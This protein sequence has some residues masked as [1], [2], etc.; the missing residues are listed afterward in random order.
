MKPLL[1]TVTLLGAVSLAG[2]GGI[3]DFENFSNSL[4]YTNSVHN[5]PPSGLI[6]GAPGAYY[7]ALF[8]ACTNHTSVDATLNNGIGCGWV[9]EALGTN[10]AIPGLMNGNYTTDPGVDVSDPDGS[11]ANFV[12]AG[13]SA[14]VGRTWAEAK[15]WWGNGSPNITLPGYFAISS[16]AR[17]VVAGGSVYPVP[18]IFGPTPI[19]EVQGFTLNLYSNPPP[20]ITGV[21]VSGT[22]VLITFPT[23]VD[24]PYHLQSRPNLNLGSWSTVANNI[25]GSGGTVTSVHAGGSQSPQHFYRVEL[26]MVRGV[27][28][29]ADPTYAGGWFDGS[30]GCTNGCNGGVGFGPWTLTA[31][32]AVGGAGNGFLIGSSTNNGSGAS[33]GIDVVG[34]SWGLYANS[35]NIAAAW[36]TF[37]LT[38]LQ[39]GQSFQMAMDNGNID[40]GGS[41]GLVLHSSILSGP[42]SSTFA[43]AQFEFLY[44]GSDPTDSYK[45][46][47][48][49]GQQNI[50]VPLTST[51]LRLVFTLHTANTY[52]LLTIDNASNTTNTHSG[53]L[54]IA[55]GAINSLTLF[56]NNAGSGPSHNVF[57]NCF[58]VS[59]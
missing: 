59:P 4:I 39:I 30:Y 31:T 32:V 55:N 47:D 8:S 14:N 7:F 44:V 24:Y 34:K 35:G 48:A 56:N 13:W 29:A 5:G 22:N 12:V 1:T 10:T 2:A 3:V 57:F 52:T 51:G 45:V 33:P 17:N 41:V 38:Q 49:G 42:P 20:R 18:T 16:I 53:T 46:V 26:P 27:D 25:V 54:A 23:V 15:A 19:Y 43:E 37:P 9:Y 40:S 50:G 21:V 28:C 36:R 11:Q 6:S 58:Q